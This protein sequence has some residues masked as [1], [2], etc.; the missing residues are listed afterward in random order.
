MRNDRCYYFAGVKGDSLIL[1]MVKHA[2]AFRK[3]YEVAL[4]STYL[5][6]HEN[7]FLTL[8]VDVKDA[9]ISCSLNGATITATDSTY[10]EGKI[11]LMADVP[12][13]Y[14]Q[15]TVKTSSAELERLKKSRER[16]THEL[17]VI[18]A[19]VPDMKAWKKINTSGFGVGRNLRFG[20][21]V[22]GNPCGCISQRQFESF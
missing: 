19:S 11:G 18:K 10:G 13:K 8:Q 9:Q 4:G 20:D 5:N 17:D 15:V 14:H 7:E 3:P 22:S 2:F 6:W 21:L 16:V 12:T 1:K